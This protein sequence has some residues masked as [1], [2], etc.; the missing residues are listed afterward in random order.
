MIAVLIA[1]V[2]LLLAVP[3][4]VLALALCRTA[5][6]A[7]EEGERQRTALETARYQPEEEK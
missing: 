2:A 4:V 6:W 5:A 3:A 1:A 7:E